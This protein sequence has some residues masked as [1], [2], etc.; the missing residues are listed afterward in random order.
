[1]GAFGRPPAADPERRGNAP[2]G[3]DGGDPAAVERAAGGR[4]VVAAVE[5]DGRVV[6]QRSR[7]VG[8]G[9]RGREEG[10]VVPVGPGRDRVQRD[11][12]RVGRGGAFGTL[13]AAI[14]RGSPG[15]LPAARRLG[16]AAVDR[17]LIQVEPD[18]AVVWREH[19]GVRL[20]GRPGLRP[21]PHASPDRAVG[22]ARRGEPSVAGAVRR[23][24]DDAIDRHPVGDAFPVAP[25]RVGRRR[26]RVIGKQHDERC[27]EGPKRAYGEDGP[28]TLRRSQ[29]RHTSV[30]A[31]PVPARHL[32][33]VAL[34]RKSI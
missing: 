7:R 3:D 23:R 17:G 2:P 8:S 30:I 22:A 32:L 12:V 25:E 13:L 5:V 31:G 29:R 18:R 16:D 11:A 21:R 9:E 10:S 34:G 4:P 15:P 1:M 33:P 24:G 27:P 26:G 14:R 19:L 20:L 28:G 6:R